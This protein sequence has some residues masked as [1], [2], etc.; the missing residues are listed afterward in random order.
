MPRTMFRKD[1]WFLKVKGLQGERR[2][3]VESEIN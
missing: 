2:S 3:L 1:G